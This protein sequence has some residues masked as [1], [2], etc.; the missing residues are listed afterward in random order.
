MPVISP[1]KG[2][3][4]NSFLVG[5]FC[6]GFVFCWGFFW[7]VFGVFVYF[8]FVLFCF[9]PEREDSHSCNI[10]GRKKTPPPLAISYS[11]LAAK[12]KFSNTEIMWG[13]FLPKAVAVLL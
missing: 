9:F 11:C 3:H 4:I 13:F 12:V 2:T 10:E 7:L 1:A 8:C 6:G 5:C